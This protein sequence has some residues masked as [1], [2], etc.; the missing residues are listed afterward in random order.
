MD[1]VEKVAAVKIEGTKSA[2]GVVA[3]GV[4]GGIV[5]SSIGHGA[6]T[7]LA[8]AVGALAGGA[9]GGAVEKGATREDGLEITVRL[10]DGE[11]IAVVQE[12][13][14]NFDVGDTVRVLS[15]P[16]GTTR[17]RH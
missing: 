17:V 1:T 9:A 15:S 8:V 5:G 12:A 3:E 2:L 4:L 10:Q 7:A 6:G 13:G 14:E 16:D 11:G